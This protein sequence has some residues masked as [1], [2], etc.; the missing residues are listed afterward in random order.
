MYLRECES[1]IYAKIG[2]DWGKYDRKV[3]TE[4]RTD[5]APSN[6]TIRPAGARAL[7]TETAPDPR[8]VGGIAPRGAEPTIL[9]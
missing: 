8:A 1:P 3:I 2:I 9:L 5:R 6:R 7:W 4:R